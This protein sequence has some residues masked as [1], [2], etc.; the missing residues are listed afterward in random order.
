MSITDTQFRI[1]V[2]VAGI[3]LVVAITAVRFC[4]R[5]SLPLKPPPPAVPHGTS[6]ELLTKSSASPVMYQDFV[7]RDAAAAGVRAPTLDELSRKLPY[8]VDDARHVL[9]VGQPPLAIAGVQLRAIRVED[10]LALEIAN[11][12]ASHLAYDVVTAPEPAA[13]CNAAPVRLFNA[14]TIRPNGREI[15]I[16]CG[17]HDGIALAVSKVET[18]E[19]H[20]LSAWYLDHVPPSAVGIE[21]RIARGHQPPETGAPCAFA[22]PQAVRSGLERGE[23]GWRDLI[24]FYARHRCQTYQFPLSYRAFR[25]D[26]E[27]SVPAVSAGM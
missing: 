5:V 7:A 11:A 10:G 26:G 2:G 16:E 1:G 21:P 14:M 15:R 17:W 4:G 24:D 9:E 27:R 22:L 25:S 8:R 6:S 23:I 20:P 18:V 13:G 12:T 3:A 19:V